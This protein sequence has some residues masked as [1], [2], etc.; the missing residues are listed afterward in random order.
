[1]DLKKLLSTTPETL[2]AEYVWCTGQGDHRA[3]WTAAGVHGDCTMK[4]ITGTEKVYRAIDEYRLGRIARRRRIIALA[5]VM[6][7]LEVGTWAAIA[8]AML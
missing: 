3:S 7:A 2:A 6:V 5:L 1:M 4:A 8:L